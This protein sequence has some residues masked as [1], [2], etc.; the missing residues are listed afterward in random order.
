MRVERTDRAAARSSRQPTEEHQGR[1]GVSVEQGALFVM[2][3][4]SLGQAGPVATWITTAG[5]AAAAE[6][7]IGGAWVLTPEGIFT[8]E[9]IRRLASRPTLAPRGRAASHG[10]IYRM[11]AAA[12][13][14]LRQVGKARRFRRA[15]LDGPWRSCDLEFVW[16]RHDVFHTAGFEAARAVGSPIVLFVDAP[17]VW[18]TRK[19]GIVRPGWGRLIERLGERPQFR[20]ADLVACVSTEVAEQLVAR[21][22]PEERILITPCSV[23][24]D[25][26]TQD[27]E[28]CRDALGL[29]GKFV[30]GWIGSFRRFHGVDMALEAA[31]TLQESI[32]ELALLLVGDGRER[33]RMQ[34]LAGSL[35]L[36]NVVFTGTVPYD[37]IPRYLATMDVAILMHGGEQEFHLSPLKLKEYMACGKAIV[38]PRVGEIA[39]ELTD[40]REALLVPPSDVGALAGSVKRLHREANLRHALGRA[41]R[42][43]V[44]RDGSWQRQVE[45]MRNALDR[46]P[47]R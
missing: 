45:R 15:A 43:K 33:P 13:Y 26:F 20:N 28:G 23:D 35:G 17:L 16:Q 29:E 18:E 47:S 1:F 32:P 39:R 40:G 27:E 30:V 9:E 41:A 24:T 21:G 31:A 25:V 4:P 12:K 22:T 8:P 38:A 34:E 46:R 36:E 6:R 2:P 11:A 42:E 7:L 37:E 3:T 5:W 14:D 44:V 10:L 19:W